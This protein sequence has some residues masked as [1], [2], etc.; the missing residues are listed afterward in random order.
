MTNALNAGRVAGALLIVQGVGGYVTNFVL[1]RPALNPPGFLVNAAPH[2]LQVGASALLGILIGAFSLATAIT[3]LP[4]LRKYSERMAL[5]FV[6]AGIVALSLATVESGTVMSLLSLSKGYAANGAD[7]GQFEA[8]RGIVAAARNWAHFTHLTV[9][10]STLLIFYAALYRFALVP[11]VFAVFGMAAVVLQLVTITRPF[12]GGQVIL[13]LLA[14]LGLA[15]LA[16][17]VWL[18]VK[19]FAVADVRAA[20]HATS[21]GSPSPGTIQIPPS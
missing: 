17:A 10:G 8:L 13:P 2:A 20:S 9:S 21:A 6:A 4:I 7:P 14:P 18:L 11:R 3:V 5:T 15:N 12:F 16:V 19:G 1:L